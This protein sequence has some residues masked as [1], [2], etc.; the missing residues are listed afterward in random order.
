MSKNVTELQ[1]EEFE[2]KV[3]K[4]DK[5]V[6]VDFWAPWC[7]PCKAITPTVDALGQIYSN[8]MNFFKVNVDENPVTPSNYDIKVIPTLIFFKDGKVVE[9]IIGMVTK[10][11]LEEVIKKL[12]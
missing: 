1:D 3:L 5:A 7:G 4:A 2:N 10:D 12:I 9:K 6:M 8:Q 11:K